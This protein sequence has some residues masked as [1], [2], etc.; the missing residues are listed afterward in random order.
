M[1]RIKSFNELKDGDKLISP[2]DKEVTGFRIDRH[3][4]EVSYRS[5]Q[6]LSYFS[7]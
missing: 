7:I 6:C 2:I 4:G 5:E 3:D 1:R